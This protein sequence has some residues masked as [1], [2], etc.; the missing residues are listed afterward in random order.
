MVLDG[1]SIE[2]DPQIGFLTFSKFEVEDIK[3]ETKKTDISVV[4]GYLLDGGLNFAYRHNFGLSNNAG[5]AYDLDLKN[6]G[7][8][9]SVGYMF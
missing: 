1:L 8:Q 5:T 6:G 3:N 4:L 7:F 2:A 9:L